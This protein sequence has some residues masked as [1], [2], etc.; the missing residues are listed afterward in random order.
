MQKTIGPG[1]LDSERDLQV[2]PVA[3]GLFP[4][5]NLKRTRDFIAGKD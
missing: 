1:G 3:D 5:I 2:A 4:Q